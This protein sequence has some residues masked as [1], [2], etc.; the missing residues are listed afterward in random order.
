MI[1]RVMICEPGRDYP[2]GD[3]TKIARVVLTDGQT[4]T[5]RLGEDCSEER[6][7][8]L[9]PTLVSDARGKRRRK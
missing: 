7:L 6:A 8:W 3:K 9:L 5:F 1:A 4:L 2:V